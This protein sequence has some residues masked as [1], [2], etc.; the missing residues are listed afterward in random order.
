[1]L[2]AIVVMSV[3]LLITISLSIYHSIQYRKKSKD[4]NIRGW[5]VENHYRENIH[6]IVISVALTMCIVLLAQYV[7]R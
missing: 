2:Y 5:I 6:M 1:M 3:G 7:G 4:N